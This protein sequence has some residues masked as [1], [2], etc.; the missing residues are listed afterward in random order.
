MSE[1]SWKVDGLGQMKVKRAT[2]GEGRRKRRLLMRSDPGGNV[3][4]V[5][6]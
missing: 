2:E 4:Y 3:V 6:G 1:K 5:S